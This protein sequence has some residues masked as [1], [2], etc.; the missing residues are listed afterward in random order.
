MEILSGLLDGETLGTPIAMV[1]RNKDQ[2]PQDYK[3][4]EVAFRPLHADATYQVK[5]GIKPAVVVAVLRRARPSAV[6]PP[7]RSPSNCCRRWRA[8]K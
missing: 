5:Y 7:V 3:E 6:S 8:R 4:M 2:R 1:V